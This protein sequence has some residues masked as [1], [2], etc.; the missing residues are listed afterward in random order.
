[1]IRKLE[2]LSWS[3]VSGGNTLVIWQNCVDG[4]WGACIRYGYEWHTCKVVRSI[5]ESF[6]KKNKDNLKEVLVSKC[7]VNERLYTWVKKGK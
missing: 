5:A 3:V 6:V 7:N 1:M 2:M 4:K